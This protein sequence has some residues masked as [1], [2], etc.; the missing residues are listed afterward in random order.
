MFY[1]LTGSFCGSLSSLKA[2]ELG[3]VAIKESLTRVG[4][5]GSEIS[6]VI[7]GQVFKICIPRCFCQ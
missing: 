2:S 1:Y 4:L 7:M 5:N 3:S 6:E